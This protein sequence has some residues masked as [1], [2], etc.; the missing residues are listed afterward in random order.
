MFPSLNPTFRGCQSK[1]LRAMLEEKGGPP[2]HERSVIQGGRLSVEVVAGEI[3]VSG[4]VGRK[5]FSLLQ[6][7]RL[8]A[9]NCDGGNGSHEPWRRGNALTGRAWTD[10]SEGVGRLVVRSHQVRTHLQGP[11]E[12]PRDTGFRFCTST[13]DFF[14]STRQGPDDRWLGRE[15]RANLDNTAARLPLRSFA[16]RCRLFVFEPKCRADRG[17]PTWFRVRH[18]SCLV[19][20]SSPY[21][22]SAECVGSALSSPPV[23]K[24]LPTTKRILKDVTRHHSGNQL[25]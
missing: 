7:R 2:G 12:C 10:L 13:S 25:A 20:Y 8:L 23:L 22:G 24:R 9:C 19:E 14:P 3:L 4:A 17:S 6:I 15:K 18:R 21:I 5:S 11:E 1:S 16:D